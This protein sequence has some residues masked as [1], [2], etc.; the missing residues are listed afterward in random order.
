MYH[1]KTD[2]SCHASCLIF[3]FLFCVLGL[4]PVFQV[5]ET[6]TIKLQSIFSLICHLLLLNMLMF[7]FVKQIFLVC[8]FSILTSCPGILQIAFLKQGKTLLFSQDRENVTNP[9]PHSWILCLYQDKTQVFFF[10]S[11]TSKS[12]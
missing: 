12:K 5:S 1:H 10:S 7:M 11:L 8:I 4:Y 9:R 3:W 6:N 2:I